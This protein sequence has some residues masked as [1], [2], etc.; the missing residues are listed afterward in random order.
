MNHA[1]RHSNK[2]TAL[3]SMKGGL[4]WVFMRTQLPLGGEQQ[5]IPGWKGFYQDATKNENKPI[6]DIHCLPAV[7]QSPTKFDTGQEMPVQIKAKASAL[8]L[9][10]TNLVLDHAIHM[11][12]IEVLHNQKN[13][14]TSSTFK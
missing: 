6:H 1:L 10:A 13:V 7:N 4:L 8:D 3:L 2:E 5:N 11:K 9:L 12:T 14:E